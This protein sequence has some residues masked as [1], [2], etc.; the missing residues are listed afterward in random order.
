MQDNSRPRGSVRISRAQSGVCEP[1]TV[2]PHSF[3]SEIM[4]RLIFSCLWLF[5]LGIWD[6]KNHFTV[7]A[8]FVVLISFYFLLFSFVPKTTTLV[9]SCLSCLRLILEGNRVYFRFKV[10]SENILL[11]ELLVIVLIS[12]PKFFSVRLPLILACVWFDLG[13]DFFPSRTIVKTTPL[14][15]QCLPSQKHIVESRTRCFEMDLIISVCKQRN[16][17]LKGCS[18]S[19]LK[20][21]TNL[22]GH[23]CHLI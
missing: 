1:W 2:Q 13:T 16:Q 20:F 3:Q 12:Q 11:D 9:S 6:F 18:G 5:F 19:L 14:E 7:W 22:V 4:M 8:L 17:A 15:M 21:K 23:F 10:R